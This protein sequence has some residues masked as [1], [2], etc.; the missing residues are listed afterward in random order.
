[1]WKS[2]SSYLNSIG[3]N[4]DSY[5]SF[6]KML[7]NSFGLNIIPTKDQINV[8]IPIIEKFLKLTN[9]TYLTSV[10]SGR[11]LVEYLLSIL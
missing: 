2:F 8:I 7:S 6:V 9:S 11:A 4:E 10:A 1:M 5:L 3:L